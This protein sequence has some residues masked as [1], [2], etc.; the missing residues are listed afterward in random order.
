[1]KYSSG[2]LPLR[3]QTF[4]TYNI[5]ENNFNQNSQYL[6][7]ILFSSKQIRV[8]LILCVQK[9]MGKVWDFRSF[10][11]LLHFVPTSWNRDHTVL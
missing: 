1:M 4:A 10:R 9:Y 8:V 11:F 6:A 3:I 2:S 5:L 7:L